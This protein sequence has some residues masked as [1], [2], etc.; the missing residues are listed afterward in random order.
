MAIS[1]WGHIQ[2]VGRSLKVNGSFCWD[3][4]T[5]KAAPDNAS[6]EIASNDLLNIKT[7]DNRPTEISTDER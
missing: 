5:D 4:Y 1:F 7:P 2:Y 3:T 6:N